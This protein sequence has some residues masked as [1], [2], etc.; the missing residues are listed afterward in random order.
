MGVWK[1]NKTVFYLSSCV[2]RGVLHS[3]FDVEYS[4]EENIP[5]EGPV[6]LLPKHQAL[7]DIVYEGILLRHW[8]GRYAYWVMKSGLPGILGLYGAV[9]IGRSLDLINLRKKIRVEKNEKKKKKLK[10]KFRAQKEEAK[11][12]KEELREKL[13]E[14][15]RNG[16]VVVVHP[17]GTRSFGEM[18]DIENLAI[19][20]TREIEEECGIKVPA[21][22][23]GIEYSS[24][25]GSRGKFASLWTLKAKVRVRVGRAYD[26][27]DKDLDKIVYESLRRFSNL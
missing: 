11:G 3:Y 12:F 8:R 5:E 20:F 19:N 16:E 7:R 10:E 14:F 1:R 15:Y 21:I 22:P 9:K 6:L 24:L 25:W 17:E 2:C 18:L 26:V 23:V 13:K 27:Q 4:G